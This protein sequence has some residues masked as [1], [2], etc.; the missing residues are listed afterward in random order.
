MQASS[1]YSYWRITTSIQPII[2]PG[3]TLH[4]FFYT[5]RMFSIFILM[6]TTVMFPCDVC[7]R[8]SPNQH[9]SNGHDR[10]SVS[11]QKSLAGAKIK[12]VLEPSR[13]QLYKN[14]PRNKE[15]PRTLVTSCT[16]LLLFWNW[17]TINSYRII[18]LFH[19]RRSIAR[20]SSSVPFTW[21]RRVFMAFLV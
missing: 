4:A 19:W 1:P 6:A 11:H 14:A 15:N 20:L 9:L 2:S 17:V 8:T 21:I 16:L 3:R 18:A 13:Y 7:C 10:T 12:I 5:Q